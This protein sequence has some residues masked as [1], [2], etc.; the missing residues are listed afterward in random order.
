L[1]KIWAK[2]NSKPMSNVAPIFFYN[3]VTSVNFAGSQSRKMGASRKNRIFNRC[4]IFEN[5][6]FCS[7]PPTFV[8][9]TKKNPYAL[10]FIAL[11]SIKQLSVSLENVCES[12]IENENKTKKIPKRAHCFRVFLFQFLFLHVCFVLAF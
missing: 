10:N 3:A 12:Y 8:V 2:K 5:T 4:Y 7:H 9:I 1:A 11:F 6:Y